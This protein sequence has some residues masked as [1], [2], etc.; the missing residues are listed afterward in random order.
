[1]LTVALILASSCMSPEA[2]LYI[3][4]ISTL[5][6]LGIFDDSTMYVYSEL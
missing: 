2:I 5:R 4:E 3:E 1:M 6:G